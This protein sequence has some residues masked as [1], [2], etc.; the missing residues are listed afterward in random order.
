MAGYSLGSRRMSRKR[1]PEVELESSRTTKRPRM[2]AVTED[3]ESST[4]GGQGNLRSKRK[5]HGDDTYD[6]LIC[7][8]FYTDGMNWAQVHRAYEAQARATSV[9]RRTIQ[10]RGLALAKKI[11]EDPSIIPPEYAGLARDIAIK[12]GVLDQL[13]ARSRL[14]K[15]NIKRMADSGDMAVPASMNYQTNISQAGSSPSTYY[16][17][18]KSSGNTY[19]PNKNPRK[20]KVREST[21][22]NNKRVR[23]NNSDSE[24]NSASDNASEICD[25]E[26]LDKSS[27]SCSCEDKEDEEDEEDEET[28]TKNDEPAPAEPQ[29]YIGDMPM[30]TFLNEMNSIGDIVRT[31]II[32]ALERAPSPASSD[33]SGVFPT[34]AHVPGAQPPY[35]YGHILTD[36]TDPNYLA[37]DPA[38]LRKQDPEYKYYVLERCKKAG[39]E[40]WTR[41]ISGPDEFVS[42]EHASEFAYQSA[43]AHSNAHS[44][45]RR[46]RSVKKCVRNY[47]DESDLPVYKCQRGRKSWTVRVV[48]EVRNPKA[49]QWEVLATILDFSDCE[50]AE[51][52]QSIKTFDVT[53]VKGRR[54]GDY[55]TLHEANAKAA[56]LCFSIKCS[57]EK[58][59]VA[60]QYS[61]E[62]LE[63]LESRIQVEQYELTKKVNALNQPFK[64]IIVVSDEEGICY[65]V[66]RVPADSAISSSPEPQSESDSEGDLLL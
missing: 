17:A 58:E 35:T 45:T 61:R 42:V 51:A 22:S 20:Q 28:L 25:W 21:Q 52:I 60:A 65:W 64:K 41:L 8:Y 32:L 38:L 47:W 27:S 9:T 16:Q 3:S 57:V 43:V 5:S 4:A 11:R 63:D 33:D 31:Q 46:Q 62:R 44:P 24:S 26:A 13:P 40:A 36:E 6:F 50:F 59:R 15:N 10:N 18:Q 29:H 19:R 2:E 34:N 48:R 12:D 66:R 54:W 53:D 1:L 7:K 30:N 37:L 14:T 23:Y 56:E 49:W 39:Y 55:P